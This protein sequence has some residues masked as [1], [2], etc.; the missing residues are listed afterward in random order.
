MELLYSGSVKLTEPVNLISVPLAKSCEN[1]TRFFAAVSYT[2]RENDT[3]AMLGIQIGKFN[4]SY[5]FLGDTKAAANVLVY[6]QLLPDGRSM[7]IRSSTTVNTAY[8]AATANMAY[9][10]TNTPKYDECIF[11]CVGA[12][13]RYQGT[14]TATIYGC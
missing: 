8:N 5:G 3:T 12:T 11:S 9:P 2:A 1:M 4:A 6:G 10:N 14:I 13:N 7:L